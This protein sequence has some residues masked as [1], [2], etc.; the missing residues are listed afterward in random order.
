MTIEAAAV[1]LILLIFKATWAAYGLIIGS[2]AGIFNYWLVAGDSFIN[3]RQKKKAKNPL[4]SYL[5]RLLL[6]LIIITYTG[7]T[8]ADMLFGALFGLTL[9]MQTYLWDA[10][11]LLLKRKS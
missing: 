11:M 3:R 9:E 2:L 5:I 7:L 8:G 10:V 6:A 1:L 4:G